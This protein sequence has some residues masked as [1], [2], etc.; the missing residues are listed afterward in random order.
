MDQQQSAARHHPPLAAEGRGNAYQA[1]AVCGL[2][3]VAVGLVFGQTVRFE[4]INL[5]DTANVYLNPHVT[6]GLTL[7]AATW[8]FSERYAGLW[9]P[10][11]WI[12][13]MLDC[14][15]YGLD[16]AGHHLTNVL[17]H[18]ATAVLLFLVLRNM[19]GRLW[20]SAF[21]AAVFAIH[22]LRVESVAWV[23]ERKDVLSG[24]FFM[25]ALGTYVGYVRHRFSLVRYLAVIVPFVLGLMAKPIL[26]TLPFLLLLL[27]YWP[28]GRWS[29]AATESRDPGRDDGALP[30]RR[31]RLGTPARL[32]LE[33]A[34]L[35]AI[36]ALSCVVAVWA[37]GS[38]GD[39]L[40]A[41]RFGLLWRTENAL[42]SSVSYLRMFFYPVG[43]ATPY[44]RPGLDLPL[45]NVAGAVLVLALV[46]LVAA[47]GWRKRP[48]LL[49][50][51]LWYLGMLVP[52][53]GII[54]FGMQTMADRFTYLPQIGLCVALTW[55]LADAWK[56]WPLRRAAYGAAAALLLAVLLGAAWRQTT[57]WRDNLTLWNHALCCTSNNR[58]AHHAL[59]NTFL[60]QG[61]IDKAI[62]QYEAALA[63]EPDYAM[64]RYNLGVALAAV[65]RL[66]E[67]IEQYQ[68][69]VRL[70]PNNAVAHNNLGNALLMQG[71]LEPAMDHCRE[72]LRLDPDF[73]EAHFNVGTISYLH[74]DVDEAIAEYRQALEA[75]PELTAVHYPLGFA[76][77]QRGRLDEAIAE[78]R[79]ALDAQ[80]GNAAEIHNSLG[81][82]LAAAGR[83]EEAEVH[84][85]TALSIRP[86]FADARYNLYKVLAEQ[87][88]RDRRNSTKI[89]SGASP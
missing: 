18:A 65:G 26:V 28:L 41:Q 64:S 15:L 70:Q 38:E 8:A 82:A 89:S 83:L 44:P 54:Q 12:S 57:F 25:L 85:Q 4:F 17:L 62:E 45:W 52:V 46:T 22:P 40:L 34:P 35:V 59:G 13:H 6:G 73:A 76:L 7:E 1:A 37:Y 71:R 30:A 29:A 53:S 36:S 5:D 2:L 75:N 63:I 77:A 24:L 78:Y 58:L 42:I 86:D 55:A 9:M 3:L 11:T 32:V 31:R 21:V 39:D 20:P 81:L 60:D 33:K 84:Y 69:T 79:K 48:Y 19:T 87:G 61:Q 72:A 56:S 80:P 68:E 49:V 88:R 51:W 43:L 67:A 50:G 47:A 74:G 66:D 14:Q 27:D 10:T 16:A 23:T